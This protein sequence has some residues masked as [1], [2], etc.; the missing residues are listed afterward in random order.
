VL[1]G[2]SEAINIELKAPLT[3]SDAKS[4]LKKGKGIKLI[5]DIKKP[6]YPTPL[7]DAV[8][9][10]DVFVGRVREDI[11]HPQALNLW[12]VADNVR[13]GAATNAVQIAEI[14]QSDYF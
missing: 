13:K 2:H 10:D 3:A 5:D 6:T 12:V 11:S 1:Y 4:L 9:H 14:L 7:T 8:G